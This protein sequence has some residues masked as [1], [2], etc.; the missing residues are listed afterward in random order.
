[1]D[2]YSDFQIQFFTDHQLQ[3]LKSEENFVYKYDFLNTFLYKPYNSKFSMKMWIVL[4][5]LCKQAI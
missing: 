1:M 2:M 4:L 5:T 3:S